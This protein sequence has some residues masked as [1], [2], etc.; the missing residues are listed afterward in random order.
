MFYDIYKA[1]Q[2]GDGKAD[3]DPEKFARES[4]TWR[5]MSAVQVWTLT[6]FSAALLIAAIVS[7]IV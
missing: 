7:A 2:V 6:V 4:F 5:T 1:L 3:T